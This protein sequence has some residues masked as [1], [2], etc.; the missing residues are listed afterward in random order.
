MRGI[1]QWRS[2]KL[3]T[4]SCVPCLQGRKDQCQCPSRGPRKKK[5]LQHFFPLQSVQMVFASFIYAV[6][7][8][9]Y[10]YNRLFFCILLRISVQN[11]L[12]IQLGCKKS[13]PA[14]VS[15]GVG[16]ITGLLRDWVTHL[17]PPLHFFLLS[18]WMHGSVGLVPFL[19]P[20]HLLG[21]LEWAP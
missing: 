3:F 18:G 19:P 8:C 14:R 16:A 15:M 13:R 1:L 20:W 11:L 2:L 10:R 17:S 4:T 12:I 6:R 21:H 7:M 5:N 9:V